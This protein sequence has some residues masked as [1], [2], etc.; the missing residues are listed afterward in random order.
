MKQRESL[1]KIGNVSGPDFTF[2]GALKVLLV[3]T[4]VED[5][6]ETSQEISI[7]CP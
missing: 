4:S 1:E 2:A 3:Y 6:I 7:G 5:I